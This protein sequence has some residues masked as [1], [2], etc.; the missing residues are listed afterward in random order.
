MFTPQKRRTHHCSVFKHPEQDI[1]R[2]FS[3]PIALSGP[4][5]SETPVILAS[6]HSGNIYPAAFLDLVKLPLKTLRNSED[7]LVD[8][9]VSGLCTKGFPLLRARFPRC[10][11]DV[12]RTPD[13]WVCVNGQTGKSRHKE[14]GRALSGTGV[15]PTMLGTGLSLYDHIPDAGS[16]R[17]R[18]TALYQPY[19]QTLGELIASTKAVHGRVLILDCHSMP[20]RPT[21]DGY[22]GQQNGDIILGDRF[23]CS[24]HGKTV[25][26]LTTLF[27]GREYRV[28]HNIPY[29][30]GFVTE[31]YGKPDAGVEVIQIEI[32]KSLYLNPQTFAPHT[33][34]TSLKADLEDIIVALADRMSEHFPFAAE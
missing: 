5:V 3:P 25:D 31:H 4:S 21:S 16:I 19:H 33:G 22:N 32:C 12:N 24:A 20:V 1:L 18:L 15:V 11:V 6:P 10:Y 28:S 29:A 8:Q 27:E 23:G 26:M 7:S 17:T 34:F 13:D 30:G 14:R 2:H 9:L